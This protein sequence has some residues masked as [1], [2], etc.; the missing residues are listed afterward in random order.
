MTGSLFFRKGWNNVRRNNAHWLVLF[1]V[2]CAALFVPTSEAYAQTAAACGNAYSGTNFGMI[3]ERVVMCIVD[4]LD[5]TL[6]T[7]VYDEIYLALRDVIMAL[8]VFAIILYARRVMFGEVR[9]LQG[10]TI[11]FIIKIMVIFELTENLSDWYP[12]LFDATEEL[13]AIVSNAL[14]SSSLQ[15]PAAAD[16]DYQTW[17]NL[18]CLLGGIFGFRN[19]AL[20]VGTQIT[21]YSGALGLIM[22][23]AFSGYI[24]TYILFGGI[25][26]VISILFTVLRAAYM[27]IVAII[28]LT[29]LLS[30]APLIL[31]SLLFRFT[32]NY[33]DKWLKHIASMILQPVILMAFLTFMIVIYD[34]VLYTGEHSLAAAILGHPVA[35][36][37]DFDLEEFYDDA[38][39]CGPIIRQGAA[40]PEFYSEFPIANNYLVPSYDVN[41]PEFHDERGIAGNYTFTIDTCTLELKDTPLIQAQGGNDEYLKELLARV[42]EEGIMFSFLILILI[43]MM[44]QVMLQQLDSI[45]FNLTGRS[46]FIRMHSGFKVPGEQ[47]VMG[48]L[49]QAR[50]GALAAADRG[51]MTEEGW[52]DVTEA[53]KT[54]FTRGVLG[55]NI[56]QGMT[57]F[58]DTT[59][60]PTVPGTGVSPDVAAQTAAEVEAESNADDMG[61]DFEN[62]TNTTDADSYEPPEDNNP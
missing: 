16:P 37:Q 50:Q 32:S 13:M 54:G 47:Q 30:L 18:D 10:E 40:V 12:Y 22:A 60:A 27:Y 56:Y 62:N 21:L 57:N 58:S 46:K 20:G 52:S 24:G 2:A 51:P 35:G 26:F 33:F 34:N 38:L 7:F 28:S 17:A 9:N 55:E 4:V 48:G 36:P 3:T 42:Q 59:E 14:T 53:A 29:F 43:T 6:I 44:M 5:D 41:G 45:I 25:L 23:G 19:G 1:L 49:Q 31:P 61:E 8:I 15:C 11:L 39:T